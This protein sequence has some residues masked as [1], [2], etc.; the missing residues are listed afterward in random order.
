MTFFY[1]LK[2]N[3]SYASDNTLVAFGKTFDEVTRKLQNDFLILD[4]WFLNNILVL[5]CD[6]CH[7]MTLGTPNNLP[8]LSQLRTVPPKNFSVS[9]SITNLTLQNTSI[10][11]VKSQTS[12]YM[13]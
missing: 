9:L 10:Q 6:K 7:F 12:G 5:N 3:V 1:S 13:L 8:N 4:E 2:V 11:Y